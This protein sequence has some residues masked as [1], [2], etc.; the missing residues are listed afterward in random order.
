MLQLVPRLALKSGARL[1]SRRNHFLEVSD[2]VTEALRLNR[3]VVA[4]ESTIITH[5]MPFPQN[6]ECALEVEE[7]VRSQNAV[8]ATIALVNGAVK[9][10]LCKREIEILGDTKISRPVKT[11][12]RDFPYVLS[13]K[14]NGGTTVAGTL[15]VCNQVGI[16]IFATGG[17]GGVHRGASETFDIS[18]DLTELG[19]CNVAVVS[20]GV[21]SILDIAKTLEYLE[22]QGVL[23]ATLGPTA[24][25]PAF[26]S[27]LS[28]HKAPYCVETA[29]AAAEII[30]AHK[31]MHL[32]S[33]LL[34]G[35]PVPE[36]YAFD[37]ESINRIIDDALVE[38]HKA[39]IS[40]KNI[41]P[42]LLEQIAGMSGGSSLKTNIALIKNNAKTAAEIAV[43]LAHLE[44]NE[45]DTKPEEKLP[46]SKRPVS[47]YIIIFLEFMPGVR[48]SNDLCT[49]RS[50]PF[51]PE[52]GRVINEID[53]HNYNAD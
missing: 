11:S 35:V 41:T 10:G 27:R 5:G 44:R 40:G 21:K 18:A 14:L 48:H 9:V 51:I 17:I 50:A 16:R 28:A 25:F 8:P 39:G 43:C 29:S 49:K 33:G 7:A 45:E 30:K 36:P 4:L 46:S 37:P 12:R 24:A 3:P 13:N 32:E 6:V 47:T 2:E 1:F 20:S 22:T 34:F 26:Y 23:V 52:P 19:R 53:A 38:A 15:V 42:F 31:D